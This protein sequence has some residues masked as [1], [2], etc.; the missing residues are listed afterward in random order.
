M[1]VGYVE[2]TGRSGH[3]VGSIVGRALVLC[4][5]AAVLT[6]TVSEASVALGIVDIGGRAGPAWSDRDLILVAA[7]FS[8]LGG[9]VIFTGFSLTRFVGVFRT[10]LVPLVAPAAA[11]LVVARY[12]SYDPYYAPYRV[13]MSDGI[14]PGSWIVFIVAFAVAA[15]VVTRRSLRV[16]L[17][18]TSAVMWLGAVTVFGAGLGH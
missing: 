8:L 3:G 13:R 15:A 12:H 16:G 5:L 17:I 7:V 2:T 14:V 18:A 6:A 11:A 10:Q 9:G 1:S 4:L